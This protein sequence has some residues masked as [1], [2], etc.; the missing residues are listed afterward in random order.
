METGR[1]LTAAILDDDVVFT[2]LLADKIRHLAHDYELDFSIICFND[3][4]KLEVCACTYDLLF[5]DIEFPEQDGI[6]W[7]RKWR[8]TEKFKHIIYVSAHD[9]YVF[10]S[11]ESCPTAFVRKMKLDEDLNAA[12]DLFKRKISSSPIQVRIP[13]GKK[14]HFFEA[15]EI[16]YLQG[17]SHYIDVVLL[18]GTGKVIRGKM[19]D[20]ER[21][22]EPYGFVRIQVSYLMNARHITGMDKKQISMKDGKSFKIS[23][24]YR[25]RV[26]EQLKV[27]LEIKGNEDVGFIH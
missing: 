24:K 4:L 3:P 13:E 20:M 15:V 17:R 1:K 7:M 6:M 14:Y 26:F 8:D 22:L 16:M 25:K 23:P 21:I 10:R 11:F 9:D 5:L 19:D 2:R 27:F 12:L 18:D